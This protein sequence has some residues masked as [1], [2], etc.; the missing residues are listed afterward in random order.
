MTSTGELVWYLEWVKNFRIV[1]D[2]ECGA[3]AGRSASRCIVC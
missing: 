3:S 2:S 1:V